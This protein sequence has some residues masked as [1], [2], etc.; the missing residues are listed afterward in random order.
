MKRRCL[1]FFVNQHCTLKTNIKTQNAGVED[2]FT[3]LGLDSGVRR[4]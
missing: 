2:E 4:P 1:H 3:I